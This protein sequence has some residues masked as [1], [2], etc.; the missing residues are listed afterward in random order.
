MLQIIAGNANFKNFII[1]WY[2]VSDSSSHSVIN[3]FISIT[4]ISDKLFDYEFF[5]A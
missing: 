1:I 5:V 2:Y 4:L 3:G